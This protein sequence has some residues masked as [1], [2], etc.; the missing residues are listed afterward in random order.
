MGFAGGRIDRLSENRTED[1][2]AEALAAPGAR[3]LVSQAGRLVLKANG[4]GVRGPSSR[5]PKARLRA[6]DWS[7]PCCSAGMR[8]GLCWP[9]PAAPNP[10]I[11]PRG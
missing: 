10:T 4:A 9:P 7:M 5:S 2:L 8:S 1:A 11:C 6:L 3:L